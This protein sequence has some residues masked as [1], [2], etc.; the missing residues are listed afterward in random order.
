MDEERGPAAPGDGTADEPGP[1]EIF[2]NGEPE[3]GEIWCSIHGYARS[4]DDQG[5]Q[6]VF[7]P[8]TRLPFVDRATGKVREVDVSGQPCSGG[9]CS[10]CFE[11]HQRKVLGRRPGRGAQTTPEGA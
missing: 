10:A 1:G 8:G 7:P 4:I 5:R 2:P 3:P 6:S 11:A 9:S